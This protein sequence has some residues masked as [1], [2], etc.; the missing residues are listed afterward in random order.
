MTLSAIGVSAVA[1]WAGWQMEHNLATS[2][3]QLLEYVAMRFPEQVEMYSEAKTIKV[4]LE[5]TIDKLS[6][7]GVSIWVKEPD[8]KILSKSS[9]MNMPSIDLVNTI[10]QTAAPTHADDRPIWRSLSGVMWES[11]D[12]EW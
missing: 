1:F 10:S 5:R 8:G 12:R 4:G 7:S 9:G 6:T 11:P 3:K 2:H